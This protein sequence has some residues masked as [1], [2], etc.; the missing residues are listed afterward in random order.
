MDFVDLA[1]RVVRP[2]AWRG[3]GVCK[4]IGL[5]L[6]GVVGSGGLFGF[7]VSPAEVGPHGIG[8][9]GVA[10]GVMALRLAL[11]FDE[12]FS[13]DVVCGL[14]IASRADHHQGCGHGFS[15]AFPGVV[16]RAFRSADVCIAP[17]VGCV[18]SA[19]T[20]WPCGPGHPKMLGRVTFWPMVFSVGG[21]AEL[22]YT[23]RN[24]IGK[25]SA[26]GLGVRQIWTRRRKARGY[27]SPVSSRLFSP[28]CVIGSNRIT[29]DLVHGPM[30][31][32]GGRC[33]L[34]VLWY[35]ST[36]FEKVAKRI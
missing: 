1:S 28:R 9:C 31:A 30:Y 10:F 34:A 36:S 16:A 17:T 25:C 5:S 23:T 7:G 6:G 2:G 4:G 33:T 29:G 32:G 24:L 21:F 11:P 13:F 15:F 14:V 22:E 26:S 27:G 18:L 35:V 20:D 3:G 8:S 12:A 19:A